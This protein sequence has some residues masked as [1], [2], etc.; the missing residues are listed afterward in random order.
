M[1]IATIDFETRSPVELKTHGIFVYATHPD[2]EIMCLGAAIDNEQPFIW[3]PSKFF[4]PYIDENT[5]YELHYR[6][7]D[8]IDLI[9]QADKIVAQNSMFE[10][11]IWNEIG[12]KRCGWPKLP[13]EKLHD[14][15]T[16]LAYHA[17][18]MNLD[19]ATQALN[20]SHQKNMPGHKVMLK[21]CKPRTPRKAER[22]ADPD[23][24]N[25][26]WWH[27]DQDDLVKLF[28]YCADDVKAERLIHN[29]LPDLPPNE[30]KI[31]LMDQRINLRGIK[32]DKENAQAI[33]DVVK[34]HEAKQIQKFI[35]LTNGVV[36]GPRSY[37]ALKK[38]VNE[39]T[40]LKLNSV[41]KD[42]VEKLLE[43]KDISDN[44]KEVLKIKSELSK[45]SVAK[46]NAML[47]R[48]SKDGRV[49]GWSAYHVAATGRWA[50][51][52]LQLHN[53]PRDC[54]DPVEYDM[55]AK[56]FRDNNVEGLNIIWSNPYYAASRC[57]R[58]ALVS[59]YDKEFLCMDFSSVEGRG[60]PYLAEEQWVLDAYAAGKSLY[61]LSAAEIFGVPYDEVNP[62]QRQIGK[63]AEL[64]LG[65]AGGIGAFASMAKGYKIDLETFPALILPHATNNELD[66]QY[67]AEALAN[68][69]LSKNRGAMSFEAAV[70]CDIIKRKW[71]VARPMITRF[72][73][74]IQDAA[75]E[76][77]KNPGTVFTVG[78]IK[79]CSYKGFLR[80][81]LPSGR[82]LHYYEPRIEIKETDWGESETLTFMGMKTVDGKTT[83]QWARLS[84][85]SGKLVENIN[86]GFCRDL[87][88]EAM[89][90]QETNGYPIVLHVHDESMTELPIGKG[91]L[92][93]FIRL[94]EIV[95]HWA[96]GM[97]IQAT[98]W[99]GKRYQKD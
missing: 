48:A 57:V 35:E 81:Q 4:T 50:S 98:G 17:L 5:T 90:R 7:T 79:Y 11:V 87:L 49:R 86:Q 52:G 3:T 64:A 53:N 15:Q 67:G 39:Q 44:V 84:T 56:L 10:F 40:G 76:A 30:R 36:S 93:E 8:I 82:V 13:L 29:T 14:T 99:V 74:Q 70:S 51:W 73:K 47:N 95:P 55:V 34:T 24:S 85:Y 9:L 80:C 19:Q 58:G 72:W 28:D 62:K 20:L 75:I 12:V 59:E 2:T 66:G 54:Y 63:V 78:K 42:V 91:D 45:S 94:A 23:W 38:W 83:R 97:P 68:M 92:K 65:Y 18:P 21:L 41:A 32:I 71:R 27:E 60:L 88:A 46:F 96:Q 69:Y 1:T 22:E 77:T 33:V 6:H 37:V 61:K 43:K 25:K 16:Q 31:W 89:L 26:L